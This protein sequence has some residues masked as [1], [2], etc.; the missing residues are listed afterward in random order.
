VRLFNPITQRSERHLNNF[1]LIPANPIPHQEAAFKQAKKRIE[2]LNLT[3]EIAQKICSFL[4]IPIHQPGIEDYFPLFY[5]KTET[6]FDYLP[7][8]TIF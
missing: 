1:I 7:E 2:A 4:E 8:K 6:L 3:K 5:E